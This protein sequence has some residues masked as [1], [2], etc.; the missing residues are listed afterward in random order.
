MGKALLH[1]HAD[2]NVAN[3]FGETA[4]AMAFENENLAVIDILLGRLKDGAPDENMLRVAAQYAGDANRTS[5][6]MISAEKGFKV[7]LDVLLK[8]SADIYAVDSQGN[9]AMAYAAKNNNFDVL[10]MLRQAGFDQLIHAAEIKDAVLFAILLDKFDGNFAETRSPRQ[11]LLHPAIHSD[12]HQLLASLLSSKHKDQ[13]NFEINN[14]EGRSALT[15]VVARGTNPA[16]IDLLV[17]AGANVDAA[18]SQK[19]TPLRLAMKPERIEMLKA[20]LHSGASLMIADE[21]GRSALSYG[22]EKGVEAKSVKLLMDAF[23]VCK[24]SDESR[25]KYVEDAM[26]IAAENRNFAA[27]EVFVDGLARMD[28]SE[29][30]LRATRQSGD[31]GMLAGRLKAGIDISEDDVLAIVRNV[32]ETGNGDLNGADEFGTTLLMAAVHRRFRLVMDFLLKNKVEIHAADRWSSQAVDYSAG[33]QDIVARLRAASIDQLKD[34]IEKNNVNA[35]KAALEKR[36]VDFLAPDG[37]LKELLHATIDSNNDALVNAIIE[38]KYRNSIDFE[39]RSSIG[40]TPLVSVVH[41]RRNVNM[42]GSLVKGG[43]NVNGDIPLLFFSVFDENTSLMNALLAAKADPNKKYLYPS[44]LPLNHA[45]NMK[46]YHHID[47]LLEAGADVGMS[48]ERGFNMLRNAVLQNI[49]SA[50]VGRMI[51][52]LEKSVENVDMFN[53]C[54]EDALNVR[55]MTASTAQVV[56]DAFKDWLPNENT[57]KVAKHANHLGM[58][59]AGMAKKFDVSE[60]E[61]VAAVQ[62]E[63]AKPGGKLNIKHADGTTLLI[64]AAK[65]NFNVVADILLN[66]PASADTSR[67][68]LVVNPRQNKT[69]INAVDKNGRNAVMYAALNGNLELLEALRLAGADL[70]ATD[71]EGANAGLLAAQAGHV[72]T[73]AF[74]MARGAQF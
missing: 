36:D 63:V 48:R 33:D 18:D 29:Y 42:I 45:I 17:K 46:R 60:D 7:L 24:M 2:A 38:S 58:L 74:F 54:C 39:E 43:A 73:M 25:R 22:A 55:H 15:E 51:E 40:Y 49:P 28:R 44:H 70:Y 23:F 62:K 8:N 68:A 21:K 35:F 52:A 13:L 71:N 32:L 67:D 57:F 61:L 6:L 56:L 69:D 37:I 65:N 47:L 41:N 27:A 16:M 20:L 34:L 14:A 11:A 4:L 1:A 19:F 9:N 26:K 31:L 3:K 10:E 59:F 50:Y 53:A 64:A 66:Y 5:M 72:E 12:D 30:T